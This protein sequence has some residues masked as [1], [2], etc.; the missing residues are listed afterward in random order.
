MTVRSSDFGGSPYKIGDLRVLLANAKPPYF[1]EDGQE[2]LRTGVLRANTANAYASL[3]A[4]SPGHGVNFNV[5]AD[6]QNAFTAPSAGGAIAYSRVTMYY[7]TG[8]R[9]VLVP[10]AL[11]GGST[12]TFRHNTDLTGLGTSVQIAATSCTGHCLH[13]GIVLFSTTEN[14]A[15][16]SIKNFNTT[17][18]NSTSGP[19]TQQ[20]SG[21]ASNGTNLAVA[22][23]RVVSSNAANGIQTSTDGLSWTART[24]TSG[25]IGAT[26]GIVGIHY[27]AFLNKF[28]KWGGSA[29][30][31]NT[32]AVI[33]STSDGFTDTVAMAALTGYKT[34]FSTVYGGMQ[35]GAA[36]STG[37]VLIPVQRN[38]DSMYGWLRSTDGATGWT[39]VSPYL[40]ANLRG[41]PNTY[42]IST[43]MDLQ[44]DSVRSRLVAF[45]SSTVASSGDVPMLYY[46]TD[47]GLTWQADNCF[48]DA[49]TSVTK[50]L[51]FSVANSID[52]AH[53]G[54]GGAGGYLYSYLGTKF[55]SVPS[56]VGTIGA[57]S[58]VAGVSYNLR[59]K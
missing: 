56:Y 29:G 42:S 40:D 50:F 54:G 18:N 14:T 52:L 3:L 48:D 25:A 6:R 59:I 51:G 28:F 53:V 23:A 17:L 5:A 46:S 47:H 26:T 27:S 12:P 58:Q 34:Q 22:T 10:P 31:G 20:Y 7:T 16:T 13:N 4:V 9:Y 24:G 11:D 36:S 2:W 30:G 8:G 32:E 15:N 35:H 21:I 57:Y 39:F 41:I 45:P 19:T 43:L 33:L 1:L 55:G 49:D 44:W 37:A 38:S